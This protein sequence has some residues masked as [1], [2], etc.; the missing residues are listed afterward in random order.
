MERGQIARIEAA[1]HHPPSGVRLVPPTLFVIVRDDFS[2]LR[3]LLVSGL[4]V[5]AL[6]RFSRPCCR[7]LDR[8][9]TLTFD[10]RLNASRIA[11]SA[12]YALLLP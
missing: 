9:E 12:L 1:P 2:A 6:M 10:G 5:R 3:S 7:N 11:L 4:S 8:A